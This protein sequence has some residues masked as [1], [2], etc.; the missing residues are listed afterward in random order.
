MEW[1]DKVT[2]VRYLIV[3]FLV[4]ALV[5]GLT[6]NAMFE[7]QGRYN[8]IRFILTAVSAFLILFLSGFHIGRFN[9]KRLILLWLWSLF[10]LCSL[11]SAALNRDELWGEL[12]Q[13]AGVPLTFFW[14]YPYLAG[15][16]GGEILGWG[17]VLGAASYI[18]ASLLTAPITTSYYKGVFFNPNTMGMILASAAVGDLILLN[19]WINK[20]ENTL[21]KRLTVFGLSAY[22]L[23]LFVLL[24]FSSSRTAFAVFVLS[25][26]IFCGFVLAR[27]QYN[28]W[29]KWLW[30]SGGIFFLLLLAGLALLG[31]QVNFL[32]PII[33]KFS[34]TPDI[35][36]LSGRENI[37]QATFREADLLGHGNQYFSLQIGRL[38]HNTYVSIL[39]MKGIVACV[40]LLLIH[41][42]AWIGAWYK[43]I[44][45]FRV[46]DYAIAPL[47]IINAYILLGF[48]ENT[49]G[50]LGNGLHVVFLMALG[51]VTHLNQTNE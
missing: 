10:S 41:F 1:N 18:I 16:R 40:L 6:M 31:D 7:D 51:L 32:A 30:L 45:Q 35:T 27:N 3:L 46:D 26:V 14:G 29:Q 21:L 39:G 49:G 11:F 43:S 44:T 20:R 22:L 50:I 17:L 19:G 9:K 2:G 13:L 42:L 48:T 4:S 37:W 8:S 23:L 47:L 28:F 12:W 33:N 36:V 38:P 15:K 5:A 34:E 24:V 25:L